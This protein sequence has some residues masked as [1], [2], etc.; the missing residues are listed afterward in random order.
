MKKW[1]ASLVTGVTSIL[2]LTACGPA[3]PNIR[4]DDNRIKD[5]ISLLLKDVKSHHPER[6]N[7][8]DAAVNKQLGQK[9]PQ[10]VATAAGWKIVWPNAVTGELSI[11][12]AP[13]DLLATY[14]THFTTDASRYT[15]GREVPSS[16][17][18]EIRTQQLG[19]DIYFAAVTDIRYS[20]KDSQWI[21]FSSTPYLPVTD[22]AYGFATV[23]NGKWKII[24]FG[25]A[26]VGCGVVPTDVQ[27]EFGLSCP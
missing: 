5:A 24:D 10:G 18:S 17:A 13:W 16:V 8:S 4:P 21:I 15:G 19:S 26:E 23:V 6:Q 12:Y 25:T 27:T 9:L 2:L 11:V 3:D 20:V 1:L 14:P 22:P 7:W